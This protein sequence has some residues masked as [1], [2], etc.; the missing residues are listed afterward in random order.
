MKTRKV[1]D[2]SRNI[3]VS[4]GLQNVMDSYRT[5]QKAI[6]YNGNIVKQLLVETYTTVSVSYFTN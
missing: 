5:D 6:Q 2:R 1:P 4:I 3:S